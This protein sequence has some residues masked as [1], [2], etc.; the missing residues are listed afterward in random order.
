MQFFLPR[1]QFKEIRSISKRGN[2]L[3][4]NEIKLNIT[5]QISDISYLNSVL[6]DFDSSATISLF[7]LNF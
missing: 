2:L 4:N 7:K 5:Y 3:D 1:F 6:N